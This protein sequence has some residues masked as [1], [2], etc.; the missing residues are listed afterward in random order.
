MNNN[1]INNEVL[2]DLIQI[3]NDRI[4]GYKRA[5][6]EL[7]PEDEDLKNIFAEMMRHSAKYKS[8]LVQEVQISG[9][10]PVTGTTTSGKIYRAWMDVK[11]MFS[12]N[13]RKAV[14]ENCEAGED[15]AK[16][17]Y[18]SALNTEHLSAN[19]RSIL[20]E[21]Q[22]EIIIAHNHIKSLRDAVS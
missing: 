8:Q 22:A 18:K 14:L 13:D 19:I 2:N 15:A 11:A 1:E 7:S 9:E 17:A 21:Q 10:E 3:N 12:G 6:D 5:M 4:E 20:I 16:E